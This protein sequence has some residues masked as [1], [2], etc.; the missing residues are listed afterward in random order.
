MNAEASGQGATA[1]VTE[2]ATGAPAAPGPYR[3]RRLV[4]LAVVAGLLLGGLVGLLLG[5]HSLHPGPRISG[6]QSLAGD[7]RATLDSDRGLASVEV[8]RLRDGK[9]TY[10]G[11][12]PDGTVPPTP[13]TPFELGSITKTMTGMLLADAVRRGEMRHDAPVSDYLPELVGTP[14]GAAT[15]TSSPP[16]TAGCRPSPRTRPGRWCSPCGATRTRTR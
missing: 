12:A 1:L 2:P 16:T 14:A 3:R 4:L 10:A 5:P 15:W 8:A 7:F 9:V 6:D 11:L 13:Q